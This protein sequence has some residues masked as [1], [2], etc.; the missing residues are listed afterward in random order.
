VLAADA[1]GAGNSPAW[2]ENRRISLRDEVSLLEPVFA[3]AGETFAL[4]GH[5]YGAAVALVAA[6]AMPERIRA[7]A[8]YEPTLFSLLD[9]EMPPP[10]E[11]DG[12]REAVKRA[13]AALGAGR[14]DAA[15]EH[16]IDY[17]MGA[18][19]WASTPEKRREPIA[20][21]VVNI[22]DWADAL[23][24]EPT[25]LAALESLDIPVL[26]MIGKETRASA[27]GVARLLA[28]A[29]P[30][31]KLVELQGMGHMGPV[32]HPE[33]VNAII[34]DFVECLLWPEVPTVQ[35]RPMSARAMA[36]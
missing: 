12:I 1:Y 4:V 30:R 17:W 25:S 9:A 13:V 26:C 24:T 8:L 6:I 2:Y 29:L 35:Q 23:F 14:K 18:G 21:S 33:T 7:L 31:V 16:F 20:A 15:A 36:R 10:N 19:A 34:A 11:A 32:T 3:R 27:R 22:E 28:T 5:S